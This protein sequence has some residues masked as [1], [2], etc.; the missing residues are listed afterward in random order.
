MMG[1]IA[2][3]CREFGLTVSEKKTEAMHL[4]SD[5]STASN[6]LR[7]EAAGRRYEQTTEFVHL[8]DN[9]SESADLDTEIKRLIGAAWASVTR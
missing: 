7:I 6:A 3:A 2:V 1:V 8:D 5:P 4:W 9:I